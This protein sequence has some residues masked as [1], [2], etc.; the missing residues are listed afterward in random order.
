MPLTLLP[1]SQLSAPE[2]AERAFTVQAM[3]EVHMVTYTCSAPL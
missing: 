1:Y 2:V 3:A